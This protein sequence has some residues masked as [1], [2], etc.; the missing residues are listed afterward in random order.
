MVWTYASIGKEPGKLRVLPKKTLAPSPRTL[1]ARTR[2]A[3]PPRAPRTAC[4]SRLGGILN[5][6]YREAA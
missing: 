5:F 4:R 3:H 6:Y 2:P 1:P